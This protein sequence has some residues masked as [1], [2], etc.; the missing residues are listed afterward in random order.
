M[1]RTKEAEPAIVS[2]ADWLRTATSDELEHRRE[3]L[4]DRLRAIRS[5]SE[6]SREEAHARVDA[7]RERARRELAERVE[8]GKLA[9]ITSAD[10]PIPVGLADVF[11]VAT[12][13]EALKLLHDAI[14]AEPIV[15]PDQVAFG[16]LSHETTA[17]RVG[18]QQALRDQI[19]QISDEFDRRAIEAEKQQLEQRERTLLQ[20]I[21]GGGGK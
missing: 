3:G 19:Q 20:R 13:D 9:A 18:A 6:R 5:R 16:Q 12:S 8:V 14:D 2:R 4:E 21:T 7:M 17:E 11:L 1:A 15:P 10:P